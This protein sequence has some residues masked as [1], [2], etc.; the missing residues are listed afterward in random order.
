LCCSST[1]FSAASIRFLL[2]TIARA[3]LRTSTSALSFA[4]S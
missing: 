2:V 4:F 1:F 3:A